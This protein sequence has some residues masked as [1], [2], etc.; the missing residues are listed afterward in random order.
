MG[1]KSGMESLFK[2]IF[3]PE[4]VKYAPVCLKHAKELNIEKKL[5]DGSKQKWRS[6]GG[7]LCGLKGCSDKT[8]HYLIFE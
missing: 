4:G 6:L 8:N 1:K 3:N 2:E 7:D 5:D